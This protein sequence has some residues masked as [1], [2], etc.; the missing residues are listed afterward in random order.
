[1][2]YK[3]IIN[4]T[5]SIIIKDEEGRYVSLID[6]IKASLRAAHDLPI[7]SIFY[8]GQTTSLIDKFTGGLRNNSSVI[9]EITGVKIKDDSLLIRFY[10]F[11]INGIRTVKAKSDFEQD[12]SGPRNPIHT[13]DA[14][15]YWSSIAPKRDNDQYVR[16]TP[17]PDLRWR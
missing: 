15:I 10:R 6:A 8:D 12:K 9:F 5:D 2:A 1:M 4:N 3:V 14:P 16:A 7:T 11:L 17:N 13:A